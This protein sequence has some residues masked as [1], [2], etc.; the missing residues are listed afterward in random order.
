MRRKGAHIGGGGIMKALYL[1]TANG[2]FLSAIL[3]LLLFSA[4]GVYS[5]EVT[6]GWSPNPEGDLKGYGV[7][8]RKS[9]DGPPYNLAGYV[10]LNEL[11]NID[12][13]T[14]TVSGL[15]IDADYHFAVTAYD[16]EGLESDFC[17]SLCVKTGATNTLC[18]SGAGNNP[19]PTVSGG[20]GGGGG[21]FI[22]TAVYKV[23][24][25]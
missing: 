8:Y 24:P 9:S 5:A 20:S 23:L 10:T 12:A 16:T 4:N 2:K 7:Y 22:A 25:E 3:I 1:R 18:S 17:P 14:F 21:C 6:L 15:D 13:P 19:V 11:T